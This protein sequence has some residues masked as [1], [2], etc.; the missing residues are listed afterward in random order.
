MV[1]H[2]HNGVGEIACDIV[3]NK[4]PVDSNL[5]TYR[6]F[7]EF[8]F[9]ICV[10]QVLVF[11]YFLQHSVYFKTW[12]KGYLSYLVVVYLNV[13]IVSWVYTKKIMWYIRKLYDQ[14]LLIDVL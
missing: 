10:L 5:R 3:V 11:E 13:L 12:I 6:L 14:H 9:L 2:A 7:V 1:K 4:K 8:F